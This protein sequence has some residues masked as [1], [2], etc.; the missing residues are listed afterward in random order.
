MRDDVTNGVGPAGTRVLVVDDEPTVR[1]LFRRWLAG[2]GHAVEV[3]DGA[4]QALRRVEAGGID[5]LV[6]DLL[7]PGLRGELLA[8][9]VRTRW[10]GIRLVV[11]SGWV[12]PAAMR[13]LAAAGA[14]VLQKPIDE[15]GLLLDAVAG[16]RD[17]G[18]VA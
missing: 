10:P 15:P 11:V 17:M 1:E 16:R 12:P 8:E 3:C 18:A 4:A 7:M 2:A 5:V 9:Q 13:G 14:A 6:T